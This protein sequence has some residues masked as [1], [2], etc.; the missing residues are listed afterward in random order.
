VKRD[1]LLKGTLI[2]ALAALIARVIG[3]L[4]KVPLVYLLGDAG[5]ASFGIA[6][7]LYFLLLTVSTVG[8]PSALSKLVSERAD[9]GG[10][11]EA[12]QIY[13]ASLAFAAVAGLVLTAL[14]IVFA[15]QYAA[16][17]DDP[18]AVPAIR[19][20]AP[21]LLLFPMIAM[22][23]GYYQGLR[24]MTPNGLSQIVEQIMR[25]GT[26]VL[27]A[28]L[29]LEWGFSRPVAVA[30]ASFGG[31]MGSI[32]AMAVLV[33]FAWRIRKSGEYA[34]SGADREKPA[35]TIGQ[36]Y[37]LIFTYSIPIILGSLA[38]PIINFI[39][40]S[41]VIPLLKGMMGYDSA[42]ETLG[43]LT[44]RAQSVAGIPV[45]L[46]IAVSQTALPVISSAFARGDRAE[47]ERRASQA[48]WLST[49]FGA[50]LVLVIAVSAKPLN[51]FVFGDVKGTHVIIL[52]TFASMLQVAMMTGN[53][54]LNGLGKLKRAAAHVYVGIA[55]K[56]A[57]TFLLTWW[58][59]IG[60]AIASTML[61]FLVIALL[62]HRMIRRDIRLNVLGG[63][64][65]QFLAAVAATGLAGWGTLMLCERWVVG[66]G[67]PRIDFFFQTAITAS[68]T[69]GLYVVLLFA[70]GVVGEREASILPG[71]FGKW[72]SR[73]VRS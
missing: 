13:R 68:V 70:F 18:E 57:A 73:F 38:V 69:G 31:V 8:I 24:F 67:G 52:L 23:R 26:A 20:L 33:W 43:I 7:N 42:K 54:I 39:D 40:S 15:P 34:G 72:A 58:L 59:G 9:T 62:N 19:A 66:L 30:G 5:M 28:W 71:R 32:G 44:G 41:T 10:M 1:S 47:V 35:R 16:L 48:M 6:Y 14:V 4:Q 27:L 63:R 46:A 65:L 64:R 45:I 3:V 55:V 56:L 29:L 11:A 17:A 50:W 25:V 21:A 51:G 22:M 2:L 49:V 36:I 12:R 61:C 60:G 37:K 53:S